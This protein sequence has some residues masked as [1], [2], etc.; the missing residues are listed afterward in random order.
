MKKQFT[1]APLCA[2]LLA[3][4]LSAEAQSQAKIAKIGWLGAGAGSTGSGRELFRTELRTLG[5][6]EGRNVAFE[7]RSA[8][9]DRERLAAQA[10]ELIRLGVSAIQSDRPDALAR[11]AR[12]CGREIE[13]QSRRR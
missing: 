2:L 3:L 1:V 5:Y 6:I 8:G 9:N 10:E 13:R 12:A 7:Y 4:S 11:V